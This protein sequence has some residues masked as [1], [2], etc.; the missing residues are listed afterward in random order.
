[1][2]KEKIDILFETL[3]K[4]VNERKLE[5]DRLNAL[6]KRI[7]EKQSKFILPPQKDACH[8]PAPDPHTCDEHSHELWNL[9]STG[10]SFKCVE[11]TEI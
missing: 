2:A 10:A 3:N 1:M 5:I 6:Q 8:V 7:T 9:D 4:S 11:H